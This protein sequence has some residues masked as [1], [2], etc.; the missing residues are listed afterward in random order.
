MHRCLLPCHVY[1]CVCP[2]PHIGSSWISQTLQNDTKCGNIFIP[3][4]KRSHPFHPFP[5][6]PLLRWMPFVNSCQQLSTVVNSCQQLS[7]VVMC[8]HLLQAEERLLSK[9]LGTTANWTASANMQKITDTNLGM[10]QMAQGLLRCTSWWAKS[11]NKLTTARNHGRPVQ[12]NNERQSWSAEQMHLESSQLLSEDW[13][14]F[15]EIQASSTPSISQHVEY[16]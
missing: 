8:V 5:A 9:A 13:Y 12:A 15:N 3:L 16:G 11:P 7:T 1:V 10:R 2:P 6:F 14:D 4:R